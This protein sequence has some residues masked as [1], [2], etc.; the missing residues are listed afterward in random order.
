MSD[1]AFGLETAQKVDSRPALAMPYISD[2]MCS[3]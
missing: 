3:T 2:G 1:K